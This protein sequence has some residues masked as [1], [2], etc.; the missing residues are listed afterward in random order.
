M[1]P[2][3]DYAVITEERER[4]ITDYLAKR[5]IPLLAPGAILRERY[6]VERLI[7]IGS[8]GHVYRV[9]DLRVEDAIAWDALKEMLLPPVDAF[10]HPRR[11]SAFERE[12]SQVASLDHPSIPKIKAWFSD[13]RHVYLVLEYVEG[14]TLE[15][16]LYGVNGFLDEQQVGGWALQLCEA[17]T[18][19]HTQQPPITFG[20]LTPYNVMLTRQGEIKLVDFGLDKSLYPGESISMVGTEGYWPP[21]QYTNQL[22]PL[23]DIYALGALLHQLLTSCD[24]RMYFPFT[25]HERMPTRLNPNVS[26]AMEAIVMKCLAYRSD[27]RWQSASEVKD[28]LIQT[29]EHL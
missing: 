21:E 28:A 15:E 26:P 16:I 17:L 23:S 25:F 8:V 6:E 10:D 22:D 27:E 29:I 4:S 2:Q 11:L 12:V 19:L 14:L 3:W 13:V 20:D 7:G 24:P 1:T 9:R 18:Y 5:T